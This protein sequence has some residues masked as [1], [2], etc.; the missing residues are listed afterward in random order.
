MKQGNDRDGQI[1]PTSNVQA[2]E[3]RI[4]DILSIVLNKKKLIIIYTTVL[5][6]IVLFVTFYNYI[7]IPA[8]KISVL[9][10]SLMFD[11]INHGQYPNGSKFVE[12]DIITAAVLQEV[13]DNNRTLK[14][15]YGSFD[16][17]KRTVTIQRYNPGLEFLNYEFKAK[18]S[19]KKLTSA[20]RY[21]IEQEFYR[22]TANIVA[23]PIFN[24][25]ITY[26][27]AD[28]YNIP[29]GVVS[30]TL[31]EILTTWLGMART[32]QGIAEYDISLV[33][34]KVDNSFI[35]GIDYFNGAD[36]LRLLLNDLN[37]DIVA[38]EK[39]PNVK[40]LG[41]EYDNK[42]Y[43]VK[44]I[45]MRIKFIQNYIMSPL[46]EIIGHSSVYK[47]KKNVLVYVKSQINILENK[48]NVL[49]RESS[50]YENM[51]LE[52]YISSP[53]PIMKLNTQ[54]ASLNTELAFYM[55]FLAKLEQQTDSSA[56]TPETVKTVQ[57][58][59]TK[60]GNAENYLIALINKFYE[61]VCKYNLDNKANFYKV[62]SFSSFVWSKTK[63]AYI[64]GIAL[65]VWCVFEALLLLPL[66][67]IGLY[68]LQGRHS[69]HRG[70][71]KY[72]EYV[73]LRTLPEKSESL[74][75]R[76]EIPK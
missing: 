23:K 29:N 36:Y 32:Y 22:Q 34:H 13:Y 10:F 35:K 31:N 52:H 65:I 16:N 19:D 17:F 6:L 26:P 12:T 49:K 8:T 70:V 11:G 9:N 56:T 61:R 15:Y 25:I 37:N 69:Q 46:F 38:L 68:H 24:L 75:Q 42:T 30:K 5:T 60:L 40:Q 63:T 3:I 66:V 39:L 41:I 28:K 4:W 57:D 44:D 76:K 51:L 2:H 21:E 54:I 27:Y 72:G 58:Y 59:L 43:T 73:Q 20:S 18:L 47:N 74:E 33:S 7:T 64:L 62:N 1:H 50:N 67:L 48:I 55:G 71:M 14:T 45:N 53:E